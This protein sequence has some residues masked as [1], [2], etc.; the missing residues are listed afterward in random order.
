MEYG[1]SMYSADHTAD[2]GARPIATLEEMSDNGP[3]SANFAGVDLHISLLTGGD[4]R[5]YVFGLTKALETESVKVDL[6][7]SDDLEFADFR[8]SPYVRFL[9]LRGNMQANVGLANKVGRIFRYY[10]RLIRYAASAKPKIFHI[11]WNNKF[12]YFDRTLLMLWYR[13]CGRRIVFT[14]HNV[15]RSKRDRKDSFL[16]RA[17]LRVQYRLSN[18]IFVHTE[19]MKTELLHDFG[20]TEESV[21]VIPFGINNAVPVTFL[22]VR[23]AKRKLGLAQNEKAILFFGRIK[24]YKG[25]D[26]LVSA[27]RQLADRHPDYRLIIAGRAHDSEEYWESIRASMTDEVKSGRIVVEARY[28]PDEDTETYFKAADVLVLPYREIFQSGVM[29]LS[30]S[31]GLPVLASDVGS[32]KDEIVEGETGFVFQP[33]NPVAL[34][35]AIERYF[36]S[37]LY[38]NLERHR[39]SIREFANEQHS[40]SVVSNRTLNVYR[41]VLATQNDAVRPVQDSQKNRRVG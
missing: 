8:E 31:F 1:D 12:E 36:S 38:S 16:N 11:L 20:I 10:A 18:H 19:K 30:H 29:F 4:D 14:A 9:N 2:S 39:G 3:R 17:T 27:F 41:E 24:R 22:T 26:V 34:A 15:N 28:I 13:L 25:L 33:E 6:I 23:D 32:L 7:G 35:D 5:P 40:W 37:D 21:T